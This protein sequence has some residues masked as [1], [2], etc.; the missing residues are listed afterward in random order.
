VAALLATAIMV[1]GRPASADEVVL[2]HVGLALVANLEL[3]DGKRLADGPVAILVHGT[4][5]HHGVEL[6]R[7]LQ[8]GLKQRGLASLAITLSLG[9]DGRKGMLDCTL[10][11]AH[12]A[13]DAVDEIA[14]WIAW[15]EARGVSEA[16]LI[17]HSG[18]A[19]QVALFASVEPLGTVRKL[20]LI[21]P[22]VEAPD[23]MARRYREAFGAD[24]TDLIARAQKLVDDGEEDA[25]IE[26]AGF[27]Q[28][29]DVRVAAAAVLD[30]YDPE[31][32][33]SAIG[34]LEEVKR[35]TLVVAAGADTVSP[36]VA[37][38]V[39]ARKPGS[40][41]TTLVLDGA[42]HA[43]KGRHMNPLTNTIADFL[44]R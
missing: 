6:V 44:R 29:K 13:S 18:G 20:V 28:C 11:H 27:L 38:H 31:Q 42:D 17:G 2:E 37:R 35:P 24:L 30:Y 23:A 5:A 25:L 9:L 4:L 22:P 7:N 10:E 12:R 1:W 32:K 21:A 41:V 39:E 16:A 34:L 15:L 40:H 43:F 8:A 26:A 19:Q 3:P 14:A 33:R 36:D